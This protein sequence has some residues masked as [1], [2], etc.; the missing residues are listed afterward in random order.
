MGGL[1]SFL[2]NMFLNQEMEIALVGLQNS[3]KTTLV[4][5]I[6]LGR[7]EADDSIPTIGFNMK[8]AKKGGVTIKMWDLG[9]QQRFRSQWARY[10]RATNCIVYVIDSSRPD[11]VE[12]S[13]RELHELIGNPSLTG[14]PLLV[15][16]N[17][18]DIDP[19]LSVDDLVTQLDLKAIAG[20]E[21]AC[22]SISAKEARNIDSV[23]NFLIRHSKK[24]PS[25]PLPPLP[26]PLSSPAPPTPSAAS[27]GARPS[28]SP[29]PI[30][31]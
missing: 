16:G 10:C 26:P 23:L 9:G 21:V 19:H 25:A 7:P 31:Q 18:N 11:V 17:K 28:S 12:E 2:R 4:N 3:G 5:T 14:L 15:L 1:L 8:K 20:R 29:I 24:S 27:A 22:Y 13:K 30:P 6:A